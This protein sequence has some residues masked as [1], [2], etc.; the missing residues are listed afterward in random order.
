MLPLLQTVVLSSPCR[1]HTTLYDEI[2]AGTQLHF[3]SDTPVP[4]QWT[5]KMNDSTLHTFWGDS[6]S[7][8]FDK[9][10]IYN[11]YAKNKGVN[12]IAS[13]TVKVNELPPPPVHISGPTESC[14]DATAEYSA[15]ATSNEQSLLW[16]W[17]AYDSAYSY[18][19]DTVNITFGATVNDI[20]VSQINRQTGCLSKPT[21]YHVAPLQLAAWP[22]PKLIK[23]CQGQEISLDQL[24]DQSG[25]AVL[26]HRSVPNAPHILSIQEN[27]F[28]ANVKLLANFS[29]VLPEVVQLQLERR[30]CGYGK[31]DYINVLVGAIDTPSIQHDVVLVGKPVEFR[32]SHA[33]KADQWQTYWYVND[34]LSSAVH[35]A[36]AVLTFFDTTPQI[37]HLH[38]V[39]KYDCA[40]DTQIEV[41]PRPLYQQD[42]TL[43]DTEEVSAEK[44]ITI[45]LRNDCNENL[46]VRYR[47]ERDSMPIVLQLHGTN[48][49]KNFSIIGFNSV[50]SIV[51]HIPHSGQFTLNATAG[52][53][54]QYTF[55]TT[56]FFYPRPTIHSLNLPRHICE[57]TPITLRATVEGERLAYR[58]DFGDNSFNYGNGIDHVYRYS[59]SVLIELTVSDP[60]G[61][62]ASASTPANII[63][64]PIDSFL[65]SLEIDHIPQKPGDSVVIFS[66][67]NTD[68]LYS[69]SP[70]HWIT[71]GI[72]NVYKAG[73]YRV[74]ITS[75]FGQ[76]RNRFRINVPYPNVPSVS[77]INSVSEHRAKGHYIVKII[78]NDDEAQYQKINKEA[79]VDL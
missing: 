17:E 7:F 11:V 29:E 5:V 25:D 31:I 73:N 76:C 3:T 63:T 75:S 48:F 33:L 49:H 42:S 15:I 69:W 18:I 13:L 58:W 23:I 52:D 57:Q 45:Q 46:I 56:F 26:Y 64:N 55:D 16:E 59:G 50:D 51:C 21:I 62:S 2:C 14:P 40:T 74:D 60:N 61:C 54:A 66:R 9:K 38:Y 67:P 19:G 70:C 24:Q 79:D 1:T 44:A 36:P 72:A 53:R 6:L 71:D 8:T 20:R 68:F 32:V 34:D 47:A 10:G 39:T 77:I 28:E 65:Y 37:I 4:C 41:Q 30:F 22:Y 27:S 43:H 78:A 35:G 12:N